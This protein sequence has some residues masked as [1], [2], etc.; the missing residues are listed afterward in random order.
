MKKKIKIISERYV[1]TFEHTVNEF[2]KTH[3]ALDIQYQHNSNGVYSVMI[4]YEEW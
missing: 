1:T 3:N 2:L 4:V